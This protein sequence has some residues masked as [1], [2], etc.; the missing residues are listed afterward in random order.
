MFG[1]GFITGVGSYRDECV[2]KLLQLENSVLAD[3]Y[4]DFFEKYVI[5]YLF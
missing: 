2:K 4:R 1:L 3:Q 5:L